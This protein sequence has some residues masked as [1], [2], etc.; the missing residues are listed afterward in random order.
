MNFNDYQDQ[1]IRTA[2]YPGK[3]NN[4]SYP[5]LGLTGEAGEVAEKIKK[6]IR[7][8][9]GELDDYNRKEIAKELGD[10]LW[11][12]AAMAFELGL[13]LDL[14][15]IMNLSKLKSRKERGVLKG[16]GDNR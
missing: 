10:A 9:E 11:Y 13:D 8:H 4:L 7:D 14:I 2:I 16:S 15:A 6:L 3:G 5:A 1:A 12:I